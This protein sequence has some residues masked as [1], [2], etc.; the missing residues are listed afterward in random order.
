MDAG[1]HWRLPQLLTELG[2]T[3][4]QFAQQA[5]IRRATISDLR[6]STDTFVGVLIGVYNAAKPFWQQARPIHLHDLL[7]VEGQP[8]EIHIQPREPLPEMRHLPNLP[9]VYLNTPALRREL[10]AKN[11][12]HITLGAMAQAIDLDRTTLSR[13]EHGH[14]QPR[15]STLVAI[16]RYC[17]TWNPRL[18]LHDVL[19]IM[20]TPAGA[21]PQEAMGAN[22][23]GEVPTLHKEN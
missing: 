10:V 23:G 8:Q 15:I 22:G 18:N 13:Q 9:N 5:G 16:Y 17:L 7:Y 3:Q 11:A 4:L 2:V 14:L 20:E 19:L 12:P 6:G 1:W 21:A